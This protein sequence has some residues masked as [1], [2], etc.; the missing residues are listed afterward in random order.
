MP[1]ATTICASP[2]ATVL[3]PKTTA[4]SP[5]PQTLPTVVV[6]TVLG[7]PAASAA[8]RAG[9]WPTPAERTLPKK[10]SSTISAGTRAR[11]SAPRM[12]T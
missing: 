12:A 4:C 11:A 1:P 5:E 9:A 2:S 3:A 7:I 6:G 10:T 8:C